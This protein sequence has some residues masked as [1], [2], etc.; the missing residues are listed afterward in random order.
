MSHHSGDQEMLDLGVRGNVDL[1]VYGLHLSLQTRKTRGK[2]ALESTCFGPLILP[3]L[4]SG[5]SQITLSH[6]SFLG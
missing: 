4:H 2:Q 3:L 5:L 1:P 6:L